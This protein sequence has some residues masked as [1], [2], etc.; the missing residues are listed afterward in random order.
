MKIAIRRSLP[1][2]FGPIFG[3]KSG[4][5]RLEI[6]FFMRRPDKHFKNRE[7]LPENVRPEFKGLIPH[8]SRPDID[9]LGKFVAD[10]LNGIAYSDDRQIYKLILSKYYDNEGECDGHMKITV[11]PRIVDLTK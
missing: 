1:P 6:D 7:R 5:F 2:Q 9:N 11:L 8:L 10:V 4:G 3:A